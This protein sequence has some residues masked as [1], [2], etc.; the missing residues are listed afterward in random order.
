MKGETWGRNERSPARITGCS[1]GYRDL[2]K[3]I[4]RH[5]SLLTREGF[6]VITI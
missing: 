4:A 6:S 2:P 1:T 3:R 5:N